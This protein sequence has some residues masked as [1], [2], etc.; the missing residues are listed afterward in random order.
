MFLNIYQTAWH[1]IQEYTI[2]D[3]DFE[4]CKEF[5]KPEALKVLH[6]AR[7]SVYKKHFTHS[8]LCTSCASTVCYWQYTL[9]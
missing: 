3:P 2:G 5:S 8:L 9:H 7:I 6:T 1:Y 4:T